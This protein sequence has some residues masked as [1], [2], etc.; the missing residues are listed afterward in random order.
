[1]QTTLTRRLGTPHPGRTA[2]PTRTQGFLGSMGAFLKVSAIEEI[3]AQQD[4]GVQRKYSATGK[5]RAKF[6]ER[7]SMGAPFLG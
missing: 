5:V 4:R 1:M 2:H 3:L 7:F 6:A